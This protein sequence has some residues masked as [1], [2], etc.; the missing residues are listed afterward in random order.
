MLLS[1]RGDH[2]SQNNGPEKFCV[3]PGLDQE[4]EESGEVG[5]TKEKW[6]KLKQ[7]PPVWAINHGRELGVPQTELDLFL[8]QAITGKIAAGDLATAWRLMKNMGVGTDAEQREFGR[9]AYENFMIIEDY[10]EALAIA[11]NL[12]G[13]NS[14]QW[15]EANKMVRGQRKKRPT[16]R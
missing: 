9:R 1:E 6:E 5:M 16:G 13:R 11:D 12:W 2:R 4:N 10:G 3:G 8:Q 15:A 7:G 14:G